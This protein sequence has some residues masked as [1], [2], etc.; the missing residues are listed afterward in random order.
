MEFLGENAHGRDEEVE[1]D[2][3][4]KCIRPESPTHDRIGQRKSQ[5]YIDNVLQTRRRL[6]S[7]DT[8]QIDPIQQQMLLQ[9]MSFKETGSVL[10]LPIEGAASW[11]NLPGSVPVVSWLL[12]LNLTK[13]SNLS[14]SYYSR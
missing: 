8:R 11:G 1:T 13:L 9:A 14:Q 5:V 2:D 10:E 6:S 7:S 12:N 4:M 3:I